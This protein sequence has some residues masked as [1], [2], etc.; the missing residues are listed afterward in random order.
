MGHV[1]FPFRSS[2]PLHRP[3]RSITYPR[4]SI[5]A[6]FITIA[7]C[8]PSLRPFIRALG[9]SLHIDPA[10]SFFIVPKGYYHSHSR[11]HRPPPLVPRNSGSGFLAVPSPRDKYERS[12]GEADVEKGMK[13]SPGLTPPSTAATAES[14]NKE[15]V[16]RRSQV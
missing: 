3:H 4:F 11:R 5:E 14:F 6:A 7:A 2:S 16:R 1:M 12:E 8:V 9:K 15:E 10:N 13:D